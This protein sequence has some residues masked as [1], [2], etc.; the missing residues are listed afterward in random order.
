MKTD[1]LKR[2]LQQADESMGFRSRCAEL[3]SCA[4]RWG[5][6]QLNQFN[7]LLEERID[8]GILLGPKEDVEKKETAKYQAEPNIFREEHSG[9]EEPLRGPIDKPPLDIEGDAEDHNHK[10]RVRARQREERP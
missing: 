8:S 2:A 1:Q 6:A 9:Q 10:Q 4:E 5:R 3:V 7:R